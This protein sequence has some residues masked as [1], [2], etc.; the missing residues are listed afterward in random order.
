MCILYATQLITEKTGSVDDL[1]FIRSKTYPDDYPDVIY[2]H[3]SAE[4]IVKY[5]HYLAE[6]NLK[7]KRLIESAP[8]FLLFTVCPTCEWIEEL[9]DSKTFS[10]ECVTKGKIMYM[11][12]KSELLPLFT[13][14]L[15]G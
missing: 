3:D 6:V 5:M 1:G 10:K 2:V 13:A 12:Y 7:F 11:Q 8:E 4:T 15:R 14:Q 9:M